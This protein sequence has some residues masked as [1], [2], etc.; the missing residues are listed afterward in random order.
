MAILLPVSVD[1]M[2]LSDIAQ[3]HEIERLSFATPWP[4]HAFEQE[5]RGNRLARYVVARTTMGGDERAV[6]FAG[7]WLMVDEAHITTFGV[8]PDWRRQGVGRRMLLRLFDLSLELRAARMTLEVRVSNLAAQA[9]YQRFG[10]AIAGTR[11]RYYTDDGE[12]AYVMTTPNLRGP[13]MQDAIA[14]ERAAQEGSG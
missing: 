1:D 12:D 4:A 11:L 2:R 8:H 5:L 10:F 6:G 7:V 3:V 14:A 13:T 9:L